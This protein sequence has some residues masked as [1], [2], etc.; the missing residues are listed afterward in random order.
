MVSVSPHE[1]AGQRPSIGNE[2]P[3]D[4]ERFQDVSLL[5]YRR[6]RQ[7]FKDYLASERAKDQSPSGAGTSRRASSSSSSDADYDR[8]LGATDRRNVAKTN[9]CNIL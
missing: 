1:G 6:S 7:A 5:I 9:V 2:W 3:D 4:R 8:P